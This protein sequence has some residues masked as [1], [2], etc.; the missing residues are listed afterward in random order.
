VQCDTQGDMLSALSFYKQCL[1]IAQKLAAR[2]PANTDWQRVLSVS[3][4]KIGDVQVG[5]DDL[6]SAL[7]SYKQG[8]EIR[9]KLAARDPANT[10]WQR[11]LSVI[12]DKIGV[13]QR[14]QGDL[15]LYGL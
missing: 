13:V 5:Q 8:L 7:S 9:E 10:D 3:C 15:P 4:S 1:E 14:A 6:P 2:D 11:D 12:Y